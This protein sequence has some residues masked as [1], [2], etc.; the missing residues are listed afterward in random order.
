[1]SCL[2]DMSAPVVAPFTDPKNLPGRFG[3]TVRRGGCSRRGDFR[4][5][6]SGAV[7]AERPIWRLE[8][9]G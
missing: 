2:P 5:V 1:M 3:R 9:Y 8:A 6:R 7:T 4:R